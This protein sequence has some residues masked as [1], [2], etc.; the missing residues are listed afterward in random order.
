LPGQVRRGWWIAA[1]ACT[2][3]IFVATLTPEPEV[4]GIGS[5]WPYWPF[6]IVQNLVLFA[7][8]GASLFLTTRS[9][10]KSI[11]LGAALSAAV[12]MLQLH[13]IRGRDASLVDLV[14]NTLGTAAGSLFAAAVD[15]FLRRRRS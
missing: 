3:L 15:T 1:I 7:P 5:D 11:A 13:V 4:H 2:A 9:H 12:E 8:L 14:S 10:A 6:D